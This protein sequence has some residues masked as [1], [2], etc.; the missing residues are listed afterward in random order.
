MSAKISRRT[1]LKGLVGFGVTLLGSV[2]FLRLNKLKF[3]SPVLAQEAPLL[4]K[5][6]DL[7]VA[8]KGSAEELLRKALSP[9]GGIKQFVKKGNR[10]VVK[11]NIAWARIPEEAANTNPEV[12]EALVKM[13][14]QAGAEKVL[15]RENP[16]N[17]YKFTFPRSGIEEAVKRAGGKIRPAVKK[18]DFQKVDLPQGKVLK[19]TEVI[20][21][22]F[23]ADV[24]INVPVAKHHSSTGLTLSMKNLMGIVKD[25]GYFHRQDLHQCIADLSTLVKPNLIIVDATRILLTNGPQGPGEV[26]KLGKIIAGV[27]PVAVDSYSATLFGM[28]GEDI[29]HIQK[30]SEMKLGEIDLNK[31]KIEVVS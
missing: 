18:G 25:R 13:C 21:D 28:K 4:G 22:V 15:V 30:A 20:K 3:F 6:P 10:V 7:V 24:L 1:F 12:V 29:G 11:P 27:D 26:K 9:L 23:R 19:N 5:R 8:E 17:P 14:Y 16:C 2:N 31:L